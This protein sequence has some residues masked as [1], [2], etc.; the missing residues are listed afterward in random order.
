M[1]K[2]AAARRSCVGVVAFMFTSHIKP[3]GYP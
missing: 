1:D 2:C 3:M